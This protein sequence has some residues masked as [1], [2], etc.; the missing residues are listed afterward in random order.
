VNAA[1][2]SAEQWRDW[3]WQMQ[4]RIRSVDDLAG[5]LD[6]TPDERQAIKDL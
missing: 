5:V 1:A 6:P 3:T 4:H 2:V